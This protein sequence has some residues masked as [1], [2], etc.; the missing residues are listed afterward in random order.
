MVQGGCVGAAQACSSRANKRPPI[1]NLPLSLGE[2]GLV[3][4]RFEQ[5]LVIAKAAGF[6]WETAKALLLLNVGAQGDFVQSDFDQCFP[7]F[8]RLQ[9][10]TACTALRVLPAARLA[11]IAGGQGQCRALKLFVSA[12][13]PFSSSALRFSRR[14]FWP[15]NA[16]SAA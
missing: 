8:T 1:C 16:A 9:E 15:S 4:R 7:T 11:I 5:L 2:L 13:L 10:K 12:S 14:A 3:Q 6:S